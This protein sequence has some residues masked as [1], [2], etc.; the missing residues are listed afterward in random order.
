[1]LFNSIDFAIFFPIVFLLYWFVFNRR[2]WLQNIF[3]LA[4]SYVFYGW[5]DWRF[6]FL[7]IAS[8]LTDYVVGLQIAKSKTKKQRLAWLWISL[9]LNIGL[10]FIFKY[11]NFFTTSFAEAFSL[12]GVSLNV[13]TLN[14]ILPV[15]I[16][17]YTLQTLSYTFEVYKGTISP[18]KNIVAFFGYVAF[19]PQLV[20]GPIE[21][22]Q[23]LLPQFFERRRF[24]YEEGK[25]GIKRVAWGLFKKIAVADVLAEHVA[26]IFS[27]PG[28]MSSGMLLMGTSLFIFQLYADFSGYSDIAI[29]TA[30]LLGFK[31][32]DNFLC[33]FFSRDVAEYWRRWHIS[34]TSWFRDYVYI[35]L[36]GSRNGRVNQLRNIMAA[37]VLSGLWHGANM[38][39]LVW[40][41]VSALTYIPL[42]F[43][44]KH[45]RH[46]DG[47]A[48]GKSVP[49]FRELVQM[50]VAFFLFS[51]PALF[52][53]SDSLQTAW[54]YI[55]T[56]VTDLQFTVTDA[57]VR[58]LY[59]IV[60]L[61]VFEWFSRTKSHPLQL[62]ITNRWTRFAIYFVVLYMT[63]GHIPATPQE[64]F[65]FQF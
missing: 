16:S 2:L 65:Y 1:M 26:L 64:F 37:F 4:T 36:G 18:T 48:E 56:L 23:Y 6:L 24:S 62:T 54:T 21:R 50:I 47:V 22:A 12:F 39:F 28:S 61:L 57:V 63:I 9:L 25:D 60:V 45:R 33:P 51:L 59:V 11:F 15:G 29:G 7:I 44:N 38:T 5:W 31:L 58:D 55:V 52:F 43:G 34:L 20:A 49:T 32:R 13:T 35:P 53:R 3:I 8:S 41:A 30:Q 27:D 19:F 17:F 10:L 42:I 14:F 46:L 40:G